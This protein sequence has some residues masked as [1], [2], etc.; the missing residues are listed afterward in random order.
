[1]LGRFH[2]TL[3]VSLRREHSL[4]PIRSPSGWRTGQYV[5]GTFETTNFRGGHCRRRLISKFKY[6]FWSS[7]RRTSRSTVWVVGSR[8][9]WRQSGAAH[10]RHRFCGWCGYRIWGCRWVRGV[11]SRFAGRGL[12][13]SVGRAR[14]VLCCWRGVRWSGR[15]WFSFLLRFDC[16][17]KDN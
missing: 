16:S 5:W 15:R 2:D 12:W 10:L 3:Q 4:T 1:M 8:S 7:T 11:C 9:L 13:G 6:S 14:G 17:F